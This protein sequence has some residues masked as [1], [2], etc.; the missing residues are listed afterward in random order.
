MLESKTGFPIPGEVEFVEYMGKQARKSGGHGKKGK[1]GVT[2][3]GVWS[4]G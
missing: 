3:K 1:V 4:T 2:D